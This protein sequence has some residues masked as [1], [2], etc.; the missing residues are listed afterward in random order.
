MTTRHLL[1][2][3]A[4]GRTGRLVLAGALDAGHRVTA[5][6]R[7]ADR[8]GDVSHERLDVRVGSACDPAFLE[9]VAPG[10][11]ALVS[12]LGPRWP[13]R[14]SASVYAEAGAA[15][16]VAAWTAGIDR[17]LLTSS[18]LL[19]PTTA[20]ST[21]VLRILV[22]PIV[23]GAREMEERVTASDLGWTIARTGF[24]TD[25]DDPALRVG[26]G[27]LPARPRAV[28]RAAVA[29]FLL[30]ELEAGRH[31]RRTVGLCA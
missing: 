13:T 12:T 4:N 14:S 5:V 16:A 22:Q 17:V 29:R 7:A 10:H 24:L 28:S 2:L 31:R 15:I 26:V 1:L 9:A 23:E 6:V 19:F 18:A 20:W 25:G 27:S 11:D 30:D 3:G 8:L 21:R